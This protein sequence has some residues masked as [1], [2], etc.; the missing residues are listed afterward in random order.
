MK[1]LIFPINAKTPGALDD[2][3]ASD[4][5]QVISSAISSSQPQRTP[6]S[7]FKFEQHIQKLARYHSKILHKKK[8]L[9]IAQLFHLSEAVLDAALDHLANY[10]FAETD[11]RKLMNDRLIVTRLIGKETEHFMPCLLQT[12][13]PKEVDRHQ[14]TVTGVA[15]LAIHFSCGWV[16]HGVFCWLVAFLRSSEILLSGGCLFVQLIPLDPCA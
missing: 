6:I 16:P 15:P 14:V 10:F 5:M 7:W 2:A 8:C 9:Q 3:V 12:M 4:T 13:E 11:F 1:E